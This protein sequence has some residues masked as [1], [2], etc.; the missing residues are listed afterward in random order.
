MITWWLIIQSYGKSADVQPFSNECS[1]MEKVPIVDAVLA[2]DC[3]FTMKTYPLITRNSLY[4]P[5]T[6]NNLIPRF[7]IREALPFVN[8]VAS[9]HCVEDVSHKIHSIIVM[10]RSWSTNIIY[11][12]LFWISNK[13][14]S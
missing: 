5:S 2:Y 9:I 6:E 1:N 8:D 4:V 7:I 14:R 12:Q 11:C 3:N 13:Q 10:K